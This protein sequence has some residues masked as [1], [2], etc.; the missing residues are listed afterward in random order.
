MS[1]FQS[2]LIA[3]AISLSLSVVILPAHAQSSESV[4]W[5][6]ERQG[7]RL[8]ANIRRDFH[9]ELQPDDPAKVAPVLAYSYKYIY[10][11]L[12]YRE[13]ALVV[14][15]HLETKDS[16]YPGY[17][18]AFNYDMPSRSRT[19]I[20]GAEVLSL[21][22]FVRLASL[23]ASSPQDVIFTWFTCTE[24]EAS[25][26]LSAFH[27]DGSKHGWGLRSWQANKGIWWTSEQ[28]PVIWSDVTASDTISFDCLHS[29][30]TSDSD[31]SFAIR[32][33]EVAEPEGE[34][35]KVTDITAKYNFSGGDSR[36][37]IVRGD[38]RTRVLTELCVESSMNKLCRGMPA[39]KR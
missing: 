33:R 29:F 39:R 15:G 8:W 9:D 20:K 13:S 30:L 35:R 16:K 34:K 1:T 18:S 2:R 19:P 3:I 4:N 27:Y 11:V 24:C 37:E 17:Y 23:E 21:L 25:Q 14:V 36:L 5:I 7:A 32:C 12:V 31:H 10:R 22:K 38:E 26:V 6:N 28:G